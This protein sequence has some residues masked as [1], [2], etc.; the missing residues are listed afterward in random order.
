MTCV[1][2][3][4]CPRSY[5]SQFLFHFYEITQVARTL[6]MFS[7]GSK[8]DNLAPIFP[9]LFTS[10]NAFS[11]GRTEHCS[12]EARGPIVASP[13]TGSGGERE[14]VYFTITNTRIIRNKNNAKGGLPEE[15]KAHRAG[16][17]LL[18]H[19]QITGCAVAAALS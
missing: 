2:V 6:I 9:N 14:R 1:L 16:H 4:V 15:A 18:R 8:S 19:Q 7:L 11:T 17:S 5:R 3:S 13:A 12:N 10:R